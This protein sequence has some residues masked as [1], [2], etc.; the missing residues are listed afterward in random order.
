MQVPD[1]TLAFFLLRARVGGPPNNSPQEKYANLTNSAVAGSLVP[2]GSG[3]ST[4]PAV[5][6]VIIVFLRAPFWARFAPPSLGIGAW[7]RCFNFG[8]VCCVVKGKTSVQGTP[9]TPQKTSLDTF[10]F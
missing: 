5:G 1:G 7:H 8:S 10:V 2:L 6:M 9:L 4:A 3:G